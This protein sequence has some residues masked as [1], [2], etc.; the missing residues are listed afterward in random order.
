MLLFE[1]LEVNSYTNEQFVSLPVKI[2]T[3]LFTYLL[4]TTYI[5]C[6]Y[7]SNAELCSLGDFVHTLNANNVELCSPGDIFFLHT[8]NASNTELC[9]FGDFVHTCNASNT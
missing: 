1:C 9:L 3:G 6:T 4:T 8:L 2:N 5:H 7:A